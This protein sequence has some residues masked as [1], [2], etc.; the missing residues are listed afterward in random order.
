MLMGILLVYS[1]CYKCL[2]SE[3]VYKLF[4]QVCF[5]FVGGHIN[6]IMAF[7]GAV[8]HWGI[9]IKT[10]KNILVGIFRFLGSFFM[11]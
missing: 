5:Y 10:N 3:A 7:C 2:I 6:V 4:I 1:L 11:M 9:A 8:C